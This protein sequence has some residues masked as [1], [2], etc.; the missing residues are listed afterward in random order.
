MSLDESAAGRETQPGEQR[1]G[2]A[3]GRVTPHS[4]RDPAARS[5][6]PGQLSH[7]RRRVG[8][9]LDRVER[10]DDV[11]AG[12]VVG[13]CLDVAGAKGGLWGALRRVG[14][15]LRGDAGGVFGTAA[16]FAQAGYPYQQTRTLALLA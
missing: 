12:V 9:V 15:L 14:A 4:D 10:R 6:D 1:L 11:E 5:A 8:R 7:C 3:A 13:Q 16:A 2:L